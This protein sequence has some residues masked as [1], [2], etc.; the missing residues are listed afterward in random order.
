MKWKFKK[1]LAVLLQLFQ[2]IQKLRKKLNLPKKFPKYKFNILIDPAFPNLNLLPPTLRQS[3]KP[4]LIRDDSL[5][6]ELSTEKFQFKAQLTSHH[7]VP[8]PY[9]T[10]IN[11]NRYNANYLSYGSE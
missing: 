8:T 7:M 9:K 3:S 1:P 10:Q 6:S 2:T 11:L 4:D 5:T